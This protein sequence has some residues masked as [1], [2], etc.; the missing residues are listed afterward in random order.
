MVGGGVS[1]VIFMFGAGSPA[2]VLLPNE[3]ARRLL[4]GFLFGLVG[5]LVSVSPVGR[6]SGAHLNPAVTLA[7]HAERKLGARDTLGYIVA[8]LLGGLLSILPLAVWGSI[9]RSVHY[10]ATLPFRGEAWLPLLGEVGVTFALV[11]VIFL[12]AS[13]RRTRPFTPWSLPPLFAVMVWLEAPLSGT[14]TNPARSLGP[15][16]LAGDLSGLWIYFLG[17][18]VGALLAV[19]FLRRELIGAHHP[20]AAR[21]AHFELEEKALLEGRLDDSSVR[22]QSLPA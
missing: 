10:G 2:P 21:V 19:A 7:F 3:S 13:H 1:V 22:A 20:P 6:I 11:T 4:T 16:V 17:P 14:S 12:L 9:G 8:Q 15:A 5:A 18:S